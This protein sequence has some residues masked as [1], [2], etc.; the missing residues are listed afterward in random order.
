MARH[1]LDGVDHFFVGDLLGGAEEAGVAAVHEQRE[2]AIGIAP[3][4]GDQVAPFRVVEGTEV[5]VVDSFRLKKDA[6]NQTELN[7]GRPAPPEADTSLGRPEPP[8]SRRP[9]PR[10]R[11]PSSS[12]PLYPP[13]QFGP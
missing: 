11:E 4:G 12:G 2:A 13:A 5:H 8:A 6:P 9:A 10:P 3:Q 1:R 7:R